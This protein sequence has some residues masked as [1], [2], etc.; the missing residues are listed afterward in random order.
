MLRGLFRAGRAER[1]RDH[2]AAERIKAI[3]REALGTS[4]AE[5][6]V[7]EIECLDPV[8]PGLETVLLLMRPGARTRAVKIARAMSEI[9]AAD[10]LAALAEPT[11]RDPG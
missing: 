8:C 10:V 11:Q 3:A 9:T 1:A 7:S 6:T 2:E 4:E 5:L